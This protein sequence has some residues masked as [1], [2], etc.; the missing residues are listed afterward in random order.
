[1]VFTISVL[2]PGYS[3]QLKYKIILFTVHTYHPVVKK[4]LQCVMIVVSAKLCKTNF[5]K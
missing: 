5:Y 4:S 2:F 1:M 3:I